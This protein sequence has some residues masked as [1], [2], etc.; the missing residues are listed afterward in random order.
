MLMEDSVIPV[1]DGSLHCR[2]AAMVINGG[3]GLAITRARGC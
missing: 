2:L 3:S 1:Y